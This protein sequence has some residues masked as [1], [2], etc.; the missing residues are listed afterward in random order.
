MRDIAPL[1]SVI[2]KLVSTDK[3]SIRGFYSPVFT[4]LNNNK[5]KKYLE[6]IIYTKVHEFCDSKGLKITVLA[7]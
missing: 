5:K 2:M 3:L 4:S 6:A 7:F 1:K